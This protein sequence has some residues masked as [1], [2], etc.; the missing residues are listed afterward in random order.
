[1]ITPN[2]GEGWQNQLIEPRLP[3]G[4]RPL[5]PAELAENLAAIMLAS[6]NL[7]ED[8]EYNKI[9]PNQFIVEISQSHHARYF[10]P[11]EG[12]V[13]QQWQA[14]LLERLTTANNRQGRNEYRLAGP[15]HIE[16]RPVPDLSP[17]QARVLYRIQASESG[18]RAKAVLPA[19]IK[20]LSGG[21]TWS[22]HPGIMTIGRAKECDIILDMPDINEK[23]LVSGRHAYLLCE[24]DRY[25]IFDGSPDGKPSLN[26]TYVG[27]Q[28]VEP[29]GHLLR[30]GDII[31][32]AAVDRHHPRTDTPGIVALRFVLDCS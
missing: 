32:L 1:M 5:R 14:Q 10:Q 29:D 3:W 11:I 4:S 22:L 13:L 23:R 26:G 21:R 15:L 9:V 30:D 2:D 17:V 7:L 20:S 25:R 19:C 12:E 8:A 27:Y 24:T 31:V 28:P 6:E 16:I 18:A